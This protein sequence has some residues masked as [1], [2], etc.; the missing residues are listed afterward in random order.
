[1]TINELKKEE[2]IIRSDIL[3]KG[4]ENNL[5]E[6]ELIWDGVVSEEKYLDTNNKYKIMWMLK[7]G[8]DADL[9][10]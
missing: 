10:F 9:G 2:E 1:M 8:Y 3:K 5:T 6:K 4:K 7:E